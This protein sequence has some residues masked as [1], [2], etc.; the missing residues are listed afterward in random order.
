MIRIALA[1]FVGLSLA[2]SAALAAC[3]A[4]ASK[5]HTAKARAEARNCA[6]RVNLGA[7]PAISANVVAGEPAP[8]VKPPTYTDPKPSPYEGPT[9]GMSKPD[10]GVRAVPTVG[11]KWSL[12]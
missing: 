4:N 1:V 12:E 11:Y 3:P 8:I 7:V 2:G 10:P 6:N 9:L 5:A